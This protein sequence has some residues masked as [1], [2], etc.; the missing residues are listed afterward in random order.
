MDKRVLA[1]TVGPT[2]VPSSSTALFSRRR[3]KDRN[4][5]PYHFTTSARSSCR[6]ERDN[7]GENAGDDD[8]A[9]G[10]NNSRIARRV[11]VCTFI[12]LCQFPNNTDTGDVPMSARFKE[13]SHAAHAAVSPQASIDPVKIRMA[14]HCN[15]K[16]QRR[17]R[18]READTF[19]RL[20][21]LLQRSS[22]EQDKA[23]ILEATAEFI[24]KR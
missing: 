10:D 15:A 22:F 5:S 6:H 7:G 21:A 17:R 11:C 19:K 3:S 8:A 24:S 13:L 18:R 20:Q 16:S 23:A 4:Q 14:G 9:F 2:S 12:C 1:T